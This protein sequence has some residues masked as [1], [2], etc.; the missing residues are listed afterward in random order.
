MKETGAH[1]VTEKIFTI[2]I[3]NLFKHS[4]SHVDSTAT[5]SA[6]HHTTHEDL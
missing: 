6:N 3:Q 4:V 1:N 5:T 2:S